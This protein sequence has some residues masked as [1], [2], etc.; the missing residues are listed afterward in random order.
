MPMSGLAFPHCGMILVAARSSAAQF[1]SYQSVVSTVRNAIDRVLV[2]QALQVQLA[3]NDV[4]NLNWDEVSSDLDQQTVGDLIVLVGRRGWQDLA[5]NQT[6]SPVPDVGD[7]AALDLYFTQAAD[8]CREAAE[9]EYGS[10][11]REQRYLATHLYALRSYGNSAHK[12]AVDNRGLGAGIARATLLTMVQA[13]AIRVASLQR[14]RITRPLHCLGCVPKH[15]ILL[16]QLL[17]VRPGS[18]F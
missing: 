9:N 12:P 14:C 6:S 2:S 16:I 1:V 18:L 7:H 13:N 15:R 10:W 3:V 4:N 5:G 17:L 8:A 11:R